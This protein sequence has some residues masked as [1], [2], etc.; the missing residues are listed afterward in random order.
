MKLPV[1]INVVEVD[2]RAASIVS[3]LASDLRHIGSHEGCLLLKSPPM[4]AGDGSWSMIDVISFNVI[5]LF[6]GR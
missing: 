3:D 5:I 2:S 6:G 1:F 4:M